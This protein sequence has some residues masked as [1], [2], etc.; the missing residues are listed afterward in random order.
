MSQTVTQQD[1]TLD[2][3]IIPLLASF[4]LVGFLFFIDEGYYDFRWMKDP[5]AWFVFGLYSLGIFPLQWAVSW[6]LFR[7]LPYWKRIL[8][9]ML[10]GILGTILIL[11]VFV[12]L[13]S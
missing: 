12:L 3:L 8:L 11:Y 5:G 6:F 10:T 13:I 2:H 9:R 1:R 7:N 4:I